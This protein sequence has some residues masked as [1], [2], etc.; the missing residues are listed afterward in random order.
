MKLDLDNAGAYVVETTH[1][2]APTLQER[3]GKGQDSDGT[4]A[5]VI[6]RKATKA[7]NG[8][9]WERWEETEAVDALAAEGQTIAATAVVEGAAGL[10]FNQR[11][12][13]RFSDE[14]AYSI[15]AT[16]GVDEQLVAFS[17]YPESG[18]GA[19]LWATEAAVAPPI[20]AT[21]GERATDRGLRIVAAWPVDERSTFTDEANGPV[22]SL[23]ATDGGSH[24][25]VTVEDP[26]TAPR[27]A[28]RRL[29]PTECE[30]LQ[31]L[32]DGWTGGQLRTARYRQLGNACATPMFYWLGRRIVAHAEGRDPNEEKIDLAT[33]IDGLNQ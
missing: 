19:D 24:R 17:V 32:P 9:D 6:Y 30:R 23:P 13:A 2:V 33:Y 3:E 31:G 27:M 15:Q 25:M 29:T 10:S 28:V 18:Q 20:A 26:V 5:A 22:P 12:E 4:R 16:P 8:N 14:T 1:E 7:H 21:D 11:D